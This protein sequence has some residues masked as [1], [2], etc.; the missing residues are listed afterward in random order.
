MSEQ[1]N[2]RS[3]DALESFRAAL[4]IYQTK[5]KRALD[6]A[7]EEARAAERWVREDQR[8]RWEQEIRKQDRLLERA[9]AELMTVRMS[10]LADHTVMQREAVKRA[11]RALAHAQEKLRLV[12]RWSRDLD[13]IIGPHI[14]RLESVREHFQHDLPKAI[15]WLHQAQIT[16]SDYIS[17][18]GGAPAGMNLPT[19]LSSTGDQPPSESP[20]DSPASPLKTE[21]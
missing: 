10:A 9:R 16:L 11:E 5:A 6:M 21:N 4:I 8:V 3:L 7:L 12:K 19:S 14:R 13:T 20:P 1:A 2:I 15:T 18:I 17:A